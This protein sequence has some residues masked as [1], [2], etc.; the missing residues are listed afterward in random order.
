MF[1]GEHMLG[2]NFRIKSLQITINY[3]ICTNNML[4]NQ[5]KEKNLDENP[6]LFRV[7]SL[8]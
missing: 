7:E 1:E 5:T 4:F 8:L 3:L 2:I 6:F